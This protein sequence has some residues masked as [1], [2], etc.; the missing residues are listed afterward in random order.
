MVAQPFKAGIWSR[1]L[2]PSAT[3]SRHSVTTLH[4][5]PPKLR[6]HFTI[7]HASAVRNEATSKLRPDKTS[8][9][10]WLAKR[11]A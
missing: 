11:S 7:F 6:Q 1:G 3:L 2:K 9:T 4:S 8:T 5:N 10:V